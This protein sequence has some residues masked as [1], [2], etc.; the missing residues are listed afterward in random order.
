VVTVSIDN[1]SI[2]TMGGIKILPSISIDE[3]ILENTDVLIL[4]G[5]NTW[6]DCVW[7]SSI[8]ICEA[9]IESA[10]CSS[11]YGFG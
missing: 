7:N 1:N 4:P 9:C 6:I 10:R 8:R 3:C 11:F 5:G 2:T